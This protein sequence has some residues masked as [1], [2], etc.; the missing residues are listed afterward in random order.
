MMKV[1]CPVTI[2]YNGCEYKPSEPIV[3][4][5]KDLEE[6]QKFGATILKESAT[7]SD[8]KKDE[9]KA[10]ETKETDKKDDKKGKKD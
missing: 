7:K 4:E 6:L 10:E 2:K 5:D 9:P 1:S 8:I 3:I